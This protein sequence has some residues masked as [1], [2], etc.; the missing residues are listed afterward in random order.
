MKLDNVR[1]STRP[2]KKY[3]AT[4]SLDSGSKRV[5]HF[6]QKGSTTFTE[7]ASMAKKKAYLKRHRVRENWNK[8]MTAGALSRWILWNKRSLTEAIA[9]FKRRFNL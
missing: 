7:G 6:G 2:E 9:D 4:F 1:R 5:V 8:P 3:M